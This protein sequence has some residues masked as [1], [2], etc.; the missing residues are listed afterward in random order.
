MA[1]PRLEPLEMHS[2]LPYGLRREHVDGEPPS[3]PGSPRTVLGR[4]LAEALARPPCYV[5]FS[6]GRD[7]SAILA[8]AVHTARTEGLPEPI[9]LTAIYAEHEETREDEWQRLVIDHLKVNEWHRY[10]GGNDFDALGPV[11]RQALERHGPFWPANAYGMTLVARQAESGTLVTGGGGDELLSPWVWRR[12]RLRD[13]LAV[14]PTGRLARLALF[15]TAPLV[16]RQQ[17]GV[18]R[19]TGEFLS[20]LH[21]DVLRRLNDMAWRAEPPRRSWEAQMEDYLDSRYRELVTGTVGQMAR[22]AGVTLVEPLFDARVVRAVTR[23]APRT[24]YASRSAAFE[25]LF[26]DLLPASILN[27][28]GKA[29]FD[30]TIWGPDTRRFLADWDGGGVDP[31]YADLAKLTAEWSRP[32]PHS[33]ALGPLQLAWL[34]SANRQAARASN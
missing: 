9:A 10:D 16:V 24:G 13:L 30:S 26:G 34:A 2:G 5:A 15:N 8:A 18:R 19:D 22:D 17:V 6:G 32:S 20:W 12:P 21:P 31:A 33:G 14:R 1:V 23:A 3:I 11:G 25:E 27:R 29:H 28:P 4:V 7:S